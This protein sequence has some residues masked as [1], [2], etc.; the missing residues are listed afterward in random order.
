MRRAAGKQFAPES[1]FTVPYTTTP[2][3]PLSNKSN[4]GPLPTVHVEPD[5]TSPSTATVMFAPL[6][7]KVFLSVPDRVVFGTEKQEDRLKFPVY[8][9]KKPSHATI[10]A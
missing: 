8:Y 3:P 2:G 1:M 6:P 9:G 5:G 10:E 7:E 4:T